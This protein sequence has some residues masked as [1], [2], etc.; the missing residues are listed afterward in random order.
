MEFDETMAEVM[1]GDVITWETVNGL[2]CWEGG[3]AVAAIFAFVDK[4]PT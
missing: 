1:E 2:V 3:D 4:C